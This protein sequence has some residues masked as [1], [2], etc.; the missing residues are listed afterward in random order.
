MAVPKPMWS[1]FGIQNKF[2][3]VVPNLPAAKIVQRITDNPLRVPRTP[4]FVKKP[5]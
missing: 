4:V 2:G 3:R 1:E 5:I